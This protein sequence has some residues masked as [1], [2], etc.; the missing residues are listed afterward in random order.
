[1]FVASCFYRAAALAL[2]LYVA[3]KKNLAELKKFQV[4]LFISWPVA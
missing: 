3:L 1:M 2:V 4:E